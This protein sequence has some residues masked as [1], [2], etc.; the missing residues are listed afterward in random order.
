MKK[1][2]ALISALCAVSCALTAC[3][4]AKPDGPSSNNNEYD[5]LNSMISASYSAITITVSNT[6][7]DEDITLES[8]YTIEYARDEITVEYRVERFADISL[9]NPT[10]DVVITLQGTAKI[11]DGVIS[12]NDAGITADIAKLSLNFK[13]EYFENINL[14][15]VFIRADVKNVSGFLGTALVCA[16]MKVDATFLDCFSEINVSYKQAGHEVVYNY[17]FTP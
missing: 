2:I 9:D 5:N 16:D 17:V 8:V 1:F 4:G 3:G 10:A 6:F 15:G 11:I 14:S 12:A 7:T 13:E